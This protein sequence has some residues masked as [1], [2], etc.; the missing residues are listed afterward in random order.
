MLF[1]AD[2]IRRV[3]EQIFGAPPPEEPPEGPLSSVC[4][5]IV[6]HSGGRT[7]AIALPEPPEPAD[8]VAVGQPNNS[9][10]T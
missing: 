9:F 4:V 1:T 7:G 10:T 6:K 8:I 2:L 3:R 5:P